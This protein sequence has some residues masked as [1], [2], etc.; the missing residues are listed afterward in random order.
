MTRW[1]VLLVDDDEADAFLTREAFRDDEPS[2]DVHCVRDG[3]EALAF[4]RREAT[5]PEAPR[6][7]LVLL[8][9]NMPGMSGHDVLVDMKRDRALRLIPVVVMS[10]SAL[11]EDV[12]RSYAEGANGYVT[13]PDTFTKLREL[14]GSLRSVW[15]EE[16]ALTP[17]RQN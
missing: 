15:L 16:S 6:A 7:D 17:E 13:K 9:L 4:L 2:V 11:G 8:D 1:N 5:H 10:T 14:A 12:D 3:R